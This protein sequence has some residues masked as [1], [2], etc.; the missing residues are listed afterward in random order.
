MQRKKTT[1][2]FVQEFHGFP[3]VIG[4]MDGTHVILTAKP[5]YQGE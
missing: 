5:S 1:K 3:N 2:H 4:I